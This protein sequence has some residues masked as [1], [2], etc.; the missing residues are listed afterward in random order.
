[1]YNISY[2]TENTGNMMYILSTKS[3]W[4]L[5]TRTMYEYDSSKDVT[6]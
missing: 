2:V 1:M 6:G 4:W 3:E 5:G